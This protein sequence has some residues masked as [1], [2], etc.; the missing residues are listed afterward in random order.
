MS[1]IMLIIMFGVSCA[2][3]GYLL[4]RKQGYKKGRKVEKTIQ[5]KL[6]YL[7]LGDSC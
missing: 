5:K 6:Q 4:G 3:I 1:T 7:S 2:A